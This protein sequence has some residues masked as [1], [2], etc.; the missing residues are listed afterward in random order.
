MLFLLLNFTIIKKWNYGLNFYSELNSTLLI[1]YAFTYFYILR[2]L[3][4]YVGYIRRRMFT[5]SIVSWLCES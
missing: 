1:K 3:G 5:T 2:N 4:V